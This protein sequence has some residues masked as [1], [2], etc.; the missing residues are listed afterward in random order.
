MC[1]S[2]VVTFAGF[3]PVNASPEAKLERC[4]KHAAKQAQQIRELRKRLAK[5][6]PA[7]AAKKVAPP[8]RVAPRPRVAPAA[9]TVVPAK[10]VARDNKTASA[11][12]DADYTA[13]RAIRAHIRRTRSYIDNCFRWGIKT[14][15]IRRR[16]LRLTLKLHYRANGT[17]AKLRTATRVSPGLMWCLRSKAK[18]WRVAPAKKARTFVMPLMLS[19]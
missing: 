10:P 7:P 8:P 2:V 5:Y 11:D 16:T 15:K 19:P 17:L 14:G 12:A 1:L 18:R 3:G 9:K 13:Y 4:R 6:E